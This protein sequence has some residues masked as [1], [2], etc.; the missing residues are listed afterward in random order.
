MEISLSLA[1]LAGVVSFLSPCVLPLVPS[2]VSFISGM[3]FEDLTSSQNAKKIRLATLANS[4]FFVL[5]FS[6]IFIALGA[7]TSLFGNV[8]FQYQDWLRIIGGIIVIIF[9][10]FIAGLFDFNFLMKEKKFMLQGK[11]SGFV[12][13]FLVGLTFG[14]GWTPCIGPILGSILIV[15]TS[16]ASAADGVQ[17]LSVYSAGL[18]VPFLLSALLFNSFLSYSK[19]IF[20]YMK[21]IKFVGGLI[22]VAFGLL[23]ISDN[24]G[25][26]SN[27]FPDFGLTLDSLQ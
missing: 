19:K 15:A 23:L 12:G 14:A 25:T 3:S 1:F 13:S 11:P 4:V 6:L 20:K 5:G 22:L 27:W 9:G 7:S 21:I 26:L 24:L 8:L 2:Y 17:L 16:K 10:L 18:A